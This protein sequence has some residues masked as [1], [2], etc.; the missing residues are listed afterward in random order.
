MPKWVK[1]AGVFLSILYPFAVF[2]LIKSG[3]SFRPIAF[4]L[5]AVLLASFL[6]TQR[7]AL[8]WVGLFLLVG[9]IVS[10]HIFFLKIYP[11]CMNFLV[12]MGFFM[13]LK[14]IPLIAVFAQKMG[15][16]MTPKVKA[17]TRKATI[18]WGI[19][20]AINT[21]ISFVTVF[22]PLSFWMIY[23]G[24]VSYILIGSMFAGEYFVRQR[25]VHAR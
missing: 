6:Q 22:L 2:F 5:L 20:M 23:N 15:H 1:T 21:L 16:P 3:H 12:C 11:V 9:L 24:F 10:D 17:Y 8:L 7:K 14:D 13:S 19:F 4:V 25:S 18:A